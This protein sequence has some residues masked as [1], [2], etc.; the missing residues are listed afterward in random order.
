MNKITLSPCNGTWIA[1]FHG[2]EEGNIRALFGTTS[3]PTPY[4]EG[5]DPQTVLKEIGKLN[6]EYTVELE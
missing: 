6:P 2:S 4:L 5:A 1:T 3:L